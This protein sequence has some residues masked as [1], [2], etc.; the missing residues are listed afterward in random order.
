MRVIMILMSSFL[1][2]YRLRYIPKNE[3]YNNQKAELIENCI[4]ELKK[5]VKK[6]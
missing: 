1:K 3:H 6:F 2:T 5:T 4:I